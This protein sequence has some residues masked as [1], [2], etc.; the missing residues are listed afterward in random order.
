MKELQYA[1]GTLLMSDDGADAVLEYAEALALSDTSGIASMPVARGGAREVARIVLGPA[2]QLF[3]ATLPAEHVELDDSEEI[4]VIAA[5]TRALGPTRAET[6]HDEIDMDHIPPHL[7][8]ED[9]Y[10]V[11]FFASLHAQGWLSE[12]GNTPVSVTLQVA[13]DLSQSPYW[14]SRRTGVIAPIFDWHLEG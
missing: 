7:L 13:G 9:R 4:A 11:D 6:L 14:R 2:S 5:A 3:A 10:R 1:G 8:N 12:P